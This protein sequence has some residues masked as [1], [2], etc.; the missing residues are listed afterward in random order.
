MDHLKLFFRDIKTYHENT[1][2]TQQI[3]RPLVFQPCTS[4]REFSSVTTTT[5]RPFIKSIQVTRNVQT[6]NLCNISGQ[7]HIQR[8]IQPPT[9]YQKRVKNMRYGTSSD[10]ICFIFLLF[11]TSSSVHYTKYVQPLSFSELKTRFRLDTKQLAEHFT[12]TIETSI[13]DYLYSVYKY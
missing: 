6:C 8:T 3:V 13:S 9:H 2:Q 11:Q 10:V 7:L 1:N 4:R 12:T 5:A